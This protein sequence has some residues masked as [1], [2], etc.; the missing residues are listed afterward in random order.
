MASERIEQ[1][2][3]ARRLQLLVDG[4]IDYAIYLISL[5]GV[6]MSWNSGAKRL[7]GY[8]AAEIIGR[9]YATFFT[10]EDQQRDLPLHALRT[11]ASAGRFETEGWR[12]RKDGSR[13]RAH[14]IVDAVRDDNGEVIGF[15]KITRDVTQ[16]ELARQ[17]LIDSET[18]FR[19]LVE[20]VVDYAIF[21]LDPSGVIQTWNSGAQ[22]IKGY[23]AD[24]II[25][26]HFSRFYSEE[27][28]AAGVPARAL[29]TAVREGRYDAEGWRVRK[30]GSKFFALVI[31][32]PIRD[33]NGELIGFAK[34]TRDITERMHAQR[35]LKDA[36]ERLA[37]SQKLDAVGQLSGGIAHD[38]N[39][40]LM[41]VIGNLE[42]AQR[43][44]KSL[45]TPNANLERSIANAVRGAQRATA[46]TSRLLAFSRR[47]P[48]D[49]K[50]LEV[51]RFLTGTADFLQRSLG[52]IVEVQVV[53]SAGVWQIEA[54]PNHLEAALV[55]LA[56]N[57][58]DA[59]PGGGKVTIEATNVFADE[60]YCRANPELSR[61]Q[62][63]LICVS[64]TGCGM[65][66][67]VSSRAFEPFFTTKELG[68]GTGLGLS[69]VYG[70][71][72]Q[73]GGHVKIY[74]E[75]DQGT[76]VKIYLPRYTRQS[77]EQEQQESDNNTILPGE[78]GEVI[79]VVEDD[80]DLRAYLAEVLRGL[81]YQVLAAAHAQAALPILE[82][83][84]RRI[85]LLLTDVVMPGMNGRELGKRAQELRPDLRVLYMT[86]Y[87][88]NAVVHHGR[89]E[90]GVELLQKPIAQTRLAARVRD[91]LDQAGNQKGRH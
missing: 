20:A 74:S 83:I 38:F 11:A 78:R 29:E 5:D 61:G 84:S 34:V 71:V 15:A 82:R 22:R 45:R 27:D 33:E 47:Q 69:Q 50:P 66:P 62:Y 30:D 17:R 77:A 53:G 13:F 19:R 52:E 24:E 49:P 37:A 26:Q 6:V 16:R 76:T 42:T 25:G 64:D 88:R 4:V 23:T 54:D 8:E 57:A 55:N 68:Q 18:R 73:S 3:D 85:D 39:N 36:Q 48:L 91:L 40:L 59:M 31:I 46:L 86:G 7:K 80:D 35:V 41:I 72:K 87:S 28:R 89:L 63:V 14:A 90:E 21:Q 2:E 56:I 58:R 9:P 79:L 70:F 32:D 44:A 43:Y 67:D 12:V 51:N 10:P 65:S 75:V 60:D 1:L 81:G